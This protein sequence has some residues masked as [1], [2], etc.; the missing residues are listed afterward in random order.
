[1]EYPALPQIGL[2]MLIGGAI[3][4]IVINSL[5]LMWAAGYIG[6]HDA[7]FGKCFLTSFITMV[8]HWV[9]SIPFRHAAFGSGFV[10]SIVIDAVVSIFFIKFILNTNWGKAFL[11]YVMMIVIAI[12]I[13]IV[14][15]LCCAGGACF[16][17]PKA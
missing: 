10:L 5:L 8:V 1:M 16:L 11:T 7:D 13:F 15:G 4:G 14:L 2:P 3:V 17:M 6:I 9:V 12:V